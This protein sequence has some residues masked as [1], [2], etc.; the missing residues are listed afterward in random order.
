MTR[1]PLWDS[2]PVRPNLFKFATSELSQDAFLCWL[3]SW[4]DREH[5]ETDKPLHKAAVTLLN[6]LLELHKIEAPQAYSTLE[7]R[8]PYKRIDILVLLNNQIAMPIE[9]KKCTTEHSD[10]LR[11]YSKIVQEDFPGL[12]LAPVYLKTGNLSKNEVKAVQNAGFAL[13]RRKAFL[14]LLENGEHRHIQS[15]IFRDYLLW[16]KG[17]DAAATIRSLRK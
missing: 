9:D 11:L 15:D 17:T 10:Q 2:P 8:R 3:L 5:R 12:T 1:K 14:R 6:G 7:I 13:L 16:L 4:A